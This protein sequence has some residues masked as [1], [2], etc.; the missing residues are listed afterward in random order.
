MKRKTWPWVVA[1]VVIVFVILGVALLGGFA[2]YIYRQTSFETSTQEKAD[3]E[4]QRV[5]SRFKDQTP[6]LELDLSGDL[7]IHRE[8]EKPKEAD[9]QSVYIMAWDVRENRLL[10]MTI[11]F[12]FVRLK[13]SGA[14]NVQIGGWSRDLTVTAQDL[15]RHGPGIVL[16]FEEPGGTRVLLWAE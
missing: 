1:G 9:L 13:A 11:P 8:L 5:R 10:R 4:F 12:W 6:Y 3:H 16:D 2:Y 14:F 15:A 7:R